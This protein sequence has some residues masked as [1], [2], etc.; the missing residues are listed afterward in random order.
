VDPE[1]QAKLQAQQAS[2]PDLVH[3]PFE[4]RHP[5]IQKWM[6]S[7]EQ[8]WIQFQRFNTIRFIGTFVV[9]FGQ[10]RAFGFSAESAFWATFTLPWLFLGTISAI[11][12][13]GR[14]SGK[15]QDVDENISNGIETAALQIL[16]PEAVDQYVKPLVDQVLQGS[17][18]LTFVGLIVALW[19]GS[20]VFATIVEGST[21]INGAAKR[22][23]LETRGL[24]LGIYVLGLVT[25]AALVFTIA[26]WPEV[27]SSALGILPGG[28]SWWAVVGALIGVSIA[29]TTMMW[30]A[31]PRRSKWWFALPGGILTM[32][33]WLLGT[34]GLELYLV[35]LLRAGSLYG[36]IAAPI[37]VMLWILVTTLAVFIG[38]TL[39]ASILLYRDVHRQNHLA[40]RHRETAAL[41][42]MD[43][44]V[45]FA[46]MPV[47]VNPAIR[48]DHESATKLPPRSK[49]DGP[50]NPPARLEDDQNRSHQEDPDSS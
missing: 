33:L 28:V 26:Q 45:R 19:S 8:R 1:K 50:A 34:L 10:R 35:W 40:L 13:V 17:A 3:R 5:R 30:L 27:W 2:I 37:A 44:A 46:E 47:M 16:T 6:D 31:N 14:V 20:R 49:T 38:I 42:A 21:L 22:N 7:S 29:S 32:V 18:G 41:V 9:V 15:R 39:N 25:L 12:T 23:Y 24:A 11:S 36:A 48:D 43:K 4:E